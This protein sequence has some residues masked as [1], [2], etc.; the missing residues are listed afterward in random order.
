MI[1]KPF[2]LNTMTLV[3]FGWTSVKSDYWGF[4]KNTLPTN[5]I[6]FFEKQDLVLAE[7][8][9]YCIQEVIS[10]STISYRFKSYRTNKVTTKV[11]KTEIDDIEIKSNVEL[12]K[13]IIETEAC[14]ESYARHFKINKLLK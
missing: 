12:F 14:Q 5:T 10:S 13:K 2:E 9:T 6:W 11:Q 3:K 7:P 1:K 4:H 8:I